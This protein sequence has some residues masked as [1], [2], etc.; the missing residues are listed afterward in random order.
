MVADTG[1]D[2]GAVVYLN[3]TI[4]VHLED[5]LVAQGAVMSPWRLDDPALAAFVLYLVKVDA[6][7]ILRGARLGEDRH[8]IVEDYVE[9]EPQQHN[10]KPI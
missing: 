1:P 6:W 7:N 8:D 9:N 2:P 4:T 3:M 5:A 10:E